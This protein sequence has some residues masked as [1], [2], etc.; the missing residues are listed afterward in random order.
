MKRTQTSFRG[1]K[2]LV[3]GGL[4][5]IGSNLVI[6]L[7][8]NGASVTII[9]NLMPE[10]GG[11]VFNIQPVEGS[12]AINYSDIRDVLAMEQL[13]QGKDY[14]FHLARQ[15]DHILSLTDPFA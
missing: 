5:F 8:K 12:V 6:A 15:T 7:V 11:N 4:G 2:V 13:V 9:D 14:I 10:Q 3:T 1:K